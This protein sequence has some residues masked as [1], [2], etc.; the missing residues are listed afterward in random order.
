MR[1]LHPYITASPCFS[2]LPGKNFFG[3]VCCFRWRCRSRL[4]L[5]GSVL[6]LPGCPVRLLLTPLYNRF[7]VVFPD[8]FKKKYLFIF[9]EYLIMG[10][11]FRVWFW[12]VCFRC[13]LLWGFWCLSRRLFSWWCLYMSGLVFVSGTQKIKPPEL[14]RGA[15]GVWAYLVRIASK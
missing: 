12:G 13:V 5:G 9:N 11:V 14:L 10:F 15:L 2:R 7:P 1:S 4:G 3:A 6:P 8:V